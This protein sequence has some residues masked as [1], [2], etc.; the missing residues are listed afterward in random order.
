MACRFG[1]SAA[2]PGYLV[3]RFA[4]IWQQTLSSPNI[5]NVKR[6]AN[7]TV[8]TLAGTSAS[9]IQA[10]IDA[11]IPGDTIQVNPGNYIGSLDFN[12]KDITLTASAGPTNTVLHG[13]N[14]KAVIIGPGGTIKGFTITGARASF[15]AGIEVRGSSTLI[16]GNVF[17]DNIQSGGGFGA[18]IGGNN[19]SPTIER[20]IFKNNSCDSQFLSGVIGFVN[21]SSPVIV[22]NI[23]ENNP[24]RGVNMTLPAGNAPLVL[25]NTFIG[26]RVGIRT[27]RRININ[28]QIYR[29][30][31]IVQNEVGLETDF[32]GEIN[33]SVWENNLVFDNTVNYQGILD[34]SWINGNISSDPLFVDANTSNYQLQIGSPA[35]DTGNSVDAPVIDFEGTAR[36]LDGDGDTVPE[37]DIGAFEAPA[38]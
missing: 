25:N 34:Q 19:S 6:R 31:I 11:A 35:I 32:G 7:S 28:A 21:S 38:L 1:R 8:T 14:A 27:D 36:P 9:V 4:S 37:V 16:I 17:D 10:L 20:N 22:N 18:A 29:N 5:L 13:N 23:F 2:G 12:G 24:C 30:N 33:N 26:N 15:G 3:I